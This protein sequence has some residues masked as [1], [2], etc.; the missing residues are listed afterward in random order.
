MK[1]IFSPLLAL[2]SVLTCANVTAADIIHND[3]SDGT[4]EGW[5]KGT[6]ATNPVTVETEADGNK[7]LKL[8]SHGGDPATEDIDI[9]VTLHN[10]TGSWR[11]N[12]NAKGATTI[13]ARFK[14]MGTEPLEMHAAFGNTLADLRTRYV[15][16]TGVVIPPDGKWHDASFS[17]ADVQMV[18][19]G[20]HGKSSATF[21]AQ[22]TLGNV[23]SVR[24]T[25]GTLGEVTGQ[26]H[27]G[28]DAPYTGWN[29]GAAI[30]AELG[31][32]DIKLMN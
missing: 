10:S 21:S 17:L 23:K 25:Q 8:I 18:P 29:S 22:E 19:L 26:G 31:I 9:K 4:T 1:K 24:F 14:N 16:K 13:S 12:F 15:V 32:D 6:A 2:A 3:F 30:N 28:D 7:Y 5:G 27:A 11:G 20:G